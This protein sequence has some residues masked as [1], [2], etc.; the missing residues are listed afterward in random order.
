MR[1]VVQ[2]SSDP[3]TDE[4]FKAV[5]ALTE[6]GEIWMLERSINKPF[7]LSE[8]VQLPPIPEKPKEA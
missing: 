6:N 3:E 1:K 4:G 7:H 8:W 5:Y 2:I